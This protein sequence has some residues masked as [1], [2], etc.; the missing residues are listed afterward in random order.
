MLNKKNWKLY[1]EYLAHRLEVDQI[2][3]GSQE[4]E[5]THLRYALEWADT[6]P[7]S[8][9]MAFRPTLP[10]YMLSS[11]LDG[12]EGQLSPQYIKKA[13]ATFRRFF[14]WLSDNQPGYK[15]L[16]LSWVN[17]LKVKRLSNIP[18]N[19]EAVT[20]EEIR[21]IAAAPAESTFERRIRAAAVFLYLSG[22][23]ISAFIS[24]PIQA[25]DIQ[26]KRITQYPSL[27]VRTKNRK[28]SQTFLLDIPDLLKVAQ[29]WDDEIRAILPP[30]GF[31]FAPLSPDTGEIDLDAVSIGEHRETLARKNLKEWLNKVGLPYHSPHKFRH[32]H[33]HYGL[34]HSNNIADFKAV[35]M[36]AMHSS[37]EITDQFYSILNDSEVQNRINS[38]GKKE[39]KRG[40]DQDE[41]MQFQEFLAWKR[42]QN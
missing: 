15:A 42:S 27:G 20:L 24:L 34:A 8:Q 11:R 35:S 38:F 30:N 40:E 28:H 41:F 16:K 25:V 12:R 26:N 4:K 13:L 3:E 17:S 1:K 2:C 29:E 36:N 31:W 32:G 18:K 5:A 37:M 21:A 10:D 33:I 9:A 39:Q 23:R 14:S 7:F 6:R 19:K 22:A